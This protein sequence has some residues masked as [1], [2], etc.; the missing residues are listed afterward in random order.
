MHKTECRN[1]VHVKCIGFCQD[2]IDCNTACK[3]A[4][5]SK[6]Q[7]LTGLPPNAEDCC[8]VLN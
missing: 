1:I 6:G 4:G 2:Y 8:C 5:F 7:C 3:H